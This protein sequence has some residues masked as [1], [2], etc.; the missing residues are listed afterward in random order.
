MIDTA[1]FRDAMALYPTG[2]VA[3]TAF[4][5]GGP[6]GIT[7]GSFFSVSLTPC[8]VGFCVSRSS[9]TWRRMRGE[10]RFC[11]NILGD[12]QER[13]SEILARRAEP[14]DFTLI[15]WSA[16]GAVVPAVSGALAWIACDMTA[17]HDAGTHSVV[18]G[19]VS[20][21]VVARTNTPLIYCRRRYYS[22]I[23]AP[24][25]SVPPLTGEDT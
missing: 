7:V 23:P 11:V 16:A 8:L 12:D 22:I 13:V 10:T 25:V 5:A 21:L 4:A 14:E 19:N 9:R 20:D 6:T 15:N 1:A 17:I 18:I 24:L 2:V 3:I